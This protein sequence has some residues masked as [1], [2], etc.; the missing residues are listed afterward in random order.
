MEALDF[1]RAMRKVD[2]EFGDDEWWFQV[3]G[4]DAL[5][6]EGIGDP[7]D[8]VLKKTDAD[9]VQASDGAD[10]WHGFGDMARGFNMLDPIKTTIVTPGLNLDGR[11]EEMGIPASIVTK[12]LVENGVVVEK[13]GLYSFFI[14]FTIGITKGRWNSLLAA[15]QQFKDD[16]GR[17]QPLWRVMPDF[18]AKHPH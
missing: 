8:W 5:V 7:K 9:G 15:L 17:N 14:M 6:E 13:T 11:F 10:S 1:R 12:Y 2:A 16:Y 3:W 4:P 18:I